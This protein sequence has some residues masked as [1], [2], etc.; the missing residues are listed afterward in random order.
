M[1]GA[2]RRRLILEVQRV[3]EHQGGL[4][5][6]YLPGGVS[7]QVLRTL[8]EHDDQALFVGGHDGHVGRGVQYGL[9]LRVGHLEALENPFG[10]FELFDH[11]AGGD[12]RRFPGNPDL[13]LR[14]SF[15]TTRS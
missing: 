6:D 1:A 5:A 15:S 7:E 12:L 4:F 11:Q 9:A 13:F 8:V 10:L 14:I 3:V 2:C